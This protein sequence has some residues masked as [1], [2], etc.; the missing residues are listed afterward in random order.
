MKKNQKNN[1]FDFDTFRISYRNFI[2]D[3]VQNAIF[4]AEDSIEYANIL[5]LTR[6]SDNEVREYFKK[7]KIPERILTTYE[8]NQE[9]KAEFLYE[10]CYEEGFKDACAMERIKRPPLITYS[11]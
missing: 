3:R 1:D 8:D 2:Y 6:K 4:N 9:M 7:I 10:V 5:N 11:K